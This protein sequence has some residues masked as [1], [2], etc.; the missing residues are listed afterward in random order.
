MGHTKEGTDRRSHF[1]GG[2]PEELGWERQEGVTC[3][4]G[5][6]TPKAAVY[7]W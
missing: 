3:D 4:L 2:T 7:V 1:E 6:W 5:H